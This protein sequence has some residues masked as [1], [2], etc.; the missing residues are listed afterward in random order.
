MRES[1]FLKITSFDNAFAEL[2]KFSRPMEESESIPL[3]E[4]SNRI[5]A[6]DVKSPVDVP[7]FPRSSRDG[8]ALLSSKTFGAEEDKPVLMKDV[9]EVLI[10]TK[11]NIALENG[12]CAKIS[13]GAMIPKGAD[14][15]VMVEYTEEDNG[16]VKVHRPTSPGENITKVGTDIKAGEVVLHQGK[17]ITVFDSG[18]LA[19][20]GLS[21]VDAYK[22]PIVAVISTGNELVSPGKPLPPGKIYD[23]N[24]V[25]IRQAVAESGGVP[26]DYGMFPDEY[27]RILEVVQSALASSDIVLVSGGTSKGSG[28]L[29]PEVVQRIGEPTFFIHGIAMKPGKPTILSSIKGKLLLTL[30]GY[31]TSALIVY[32]ML[33]DP[34]IRKMARESP[35]E[36]RKVKAYTTAKLYSE[37]GRREF[38]PCRISSSNEG[39]LHVT[40]MPTGSEAITTLAN[41]DGFVIID[42][43]VEIVGENQEVDLFVFPH[44]TSSINQLT[45]E[46]CR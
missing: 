34:C 6:K 44:R 43:N 12:E 41:S 15:V 38:K 24:S 2:Q 37:I 16:R 26:K 36:L 29:M 42:E 9:G 33:V 22:R 1:V 31:P 35:Y 17:R 30:P 4:S 46:G 7:S 11:P 25:T 13:T 32:Y 23:V 45:R 27:P 40:P 28:D 8:Y 3:I 10:G 18:V 19:S 39:K 21:Q 20:I 14:S 5:A